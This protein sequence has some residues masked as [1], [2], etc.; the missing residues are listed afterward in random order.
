MYSDNPKP[1]KECLNLILENVLIQTKGGKNEK[2]KQFFNSIDIDND[3]QFPY[4]E[5]PPGGG[6]TTGL[7]N[8]FKN[9]PYADIV[10]VSTHL[11]QK[12]IEEIGGIPQFD[13]LTINGEEKLATI[14][15]F[16]DI[17]KT[18]YEKAE[19]HEIVV[20]LLD[21]S[22][23]LT[24]THMALLY[25]LLTEKKLRD[26]K[27]PDNVAIVLAGNKGNKAG[28]KTKF[29]AIVNR[30]DF[31]P[32]YTPLEDWVN[33]FAILNKVHP[34]VISFLKHD[35]YK[36]YFHEE[37]KVDEPWGSPRSWTRLANFLS[38]KEI[39]NNN[40]PLE[41]HMVLYL[42]QGHVSNDA[43]NK[44]TTYYSVYKQFNCEDILR[45]VDKVQLP[46]DLIDRYSMIFAVAD[47]FLGLEKDKRNRLYDN[48]AKL[49]IKYKNENSA[50][51]A[52]STIQYVRDVSKYRLNNY[53][54]TTKIWDSMNKFD[55]EI[56]NEFCDAL[57]DISEPDSN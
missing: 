4:L 47:Y 22:H 13:K 16:P 28:A 49:I 32:V 27:L 34:A 38:F 54:I 1:L 5:G 11:S 30:I 21:D 31:M 53:Q 50:E 7:M 46:E 35:Q 3:I 42:A 51:L 17:M 2:W 9:Y 43:A 23:L 48:F 15:S 25:E 6:K 55:P 19:T 8:F 39:F 57:I 40:K 29:S 41:S 26:Y 14:W 18:L 33:D 37:E 44:F 36:A 52:I 12:P 24:P 56:T 20:W 10:L 45:N